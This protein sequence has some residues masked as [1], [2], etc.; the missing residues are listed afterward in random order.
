M[1]YSRAFFYFC[2]SKSWTQKQKY[3]KELFVSLYIVFIHSYIL[4]IIFISWFLLLKKKRRKFCDVKLELNVRFK[5]NYI[6]F[7]LVLIIYNL[8]QSFPTSVLSSFF[9]VSLEFERLFYVS[10]IYFLGGKLRYCMTSWFT[11]K[12]T[13]ILTIYF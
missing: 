12:N 8:Y 2:I 5:L 3:V 6:I 1:D 11:K 4:S 13:E 10:F 7:T 9:Y